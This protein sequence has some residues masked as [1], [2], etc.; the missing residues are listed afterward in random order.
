MAFLAAHHA[1]GHWDGREQA[2]LEGLKKGRVKARKAISRKARE[3]YADLLPVI[4]G[5][6]EEGLSFQKIA[7]HLN[8]EGHRTRTG[9]PF[10]PPG[11]RRIL[12]RGD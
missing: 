7:D 5:L 1:D 9:R 2:R 12:L 3:E 4:R 10:G 6:R 11:V 8:A